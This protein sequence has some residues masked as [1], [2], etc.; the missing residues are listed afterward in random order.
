VGFAVVGAFAF[1]VVGAAGVV[2]GALLVAGL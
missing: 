1:A 2:A